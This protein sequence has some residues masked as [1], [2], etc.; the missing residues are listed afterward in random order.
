MPSCAYSLAWFIDAQSF[1]KSNRLGEF[2][3]AVLV[4]IA[5]AQLIH[6]LM[7]C[8]AVSGSRL[9]L[10][11]CRDW[12]AL[13]VLCAGARASGKEHANLLGRVLGFDVARLPV[14][15]AKSI[16]RR[17]KLAPGDQR[18]KVGSRSR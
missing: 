11:T 7:A 5:L 18:A 8:S 9:P 16:R 14:A 17:F 1:L 12:A 6:V 4:R 10:Q 3:R 15:K 2:Q 13:V